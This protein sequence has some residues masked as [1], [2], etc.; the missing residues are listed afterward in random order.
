MAVNADK[1]SVFNGIFCRLYLILSLSKVSC[2]DQIIGNNMPCQE[3]SLLC[4]LL[5]VFTFTALNYFLLF[6][7][8]GLYLMPCMLLLVHM[9][10][11]SLWIILKPIQ[12]VI[13][14]L[15]EIKVMLLDIMMLMLCI[16][17]RIQ[18]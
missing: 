16:S 1:T 11:R 10:N 9:Q 2:Q 18:F 6:F 14:P 12:L 13:S 7:V 4:W 17:F 3:E 15:E 8:S 5:F